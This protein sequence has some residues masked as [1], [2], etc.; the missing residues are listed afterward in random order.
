MSASKRFRRRRFLK[1]AGTCIAL[2]ALEV[3]APLTESASAGEKVLPTTPAGQ[4]LRMAFLTVPDG[5]NVQ[6]WRPSGVGREYQLSETL[7]PLDALREKFQV[8]S[9]LEH[10]NAY[11]LGDGGGDHARANAAFLTGAHPVK[12]SGANFRNGV[13]VD[14]IAAKKMGHLTRIASLQLGSK[15]GRLTG[16]CDSGY[17][18]AYQFNLSWASPTLRTLALLASGVQRRFCHRRLSQ[19]RCR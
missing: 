14:Q 12:T 10:R 2:P 8:F 13:S 5:V 3:F 9:E 19:F 6:R 16:D 7:K 17:S 1:G 4:P 15:A 11:A 18:C